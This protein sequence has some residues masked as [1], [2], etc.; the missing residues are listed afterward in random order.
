MLKNLFRF[1]SLLV[2]LSISLSVTGVALAKPGGDLAAASPQDSANPTIS[3]WFKTWADNKT[4]ASVGSYPSVA[5]SP[6]DGLAYISYYDA[7]NH[8][9]MLTSPAA[10]GN[11][12]TSNSWWCRPVDGTG[13]NGSSTDNVGQYSSIAFWKG[14]TSWKLGISY[15]DSTHHA[16]K[17]AVFTQNPSSW[18][19]DF[20]TI[21]NDSAPFGSQDAGLYSSLEFT[22]DGKP[23]IAYYVSMWIS[24]TSS[25]MGVL[26]IA[27]SV[28][29]GGNCGVGTNAVG[30][31]NCE[32]IDADAG[33]GL[34]MYASLD[35]DLYDYP[36]ISYY[37]AVNGNLRYAY[38]LVIVGGGNCGDSGDYQCTTID[39]AGNVGLFTS[40]I[41][42][43]TGSQKTQI[44][45]YDK[46]NGYLMVAIPWTGGTGCNT[47]NWFCNNIKTIGANLSQVGI[48]MARDKDGRPIIA[49][50][51][52]SDDAA[53]A[54]L[55]IARPVEAVGL[56]F[57]NCGQVPPGYLFQVWACDTIDAGGSSYVNVGD[58]ASIA[59]NSNGLASI[60]YSE[61]DSYPYPN[62]FYLKVAYQ[63]IQTHLPLVKK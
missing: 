56:S 29:S 19:W 2:I 14:T 52:A 38:H 53:P 44:A 11:C 46:T 28:S 33:A 48:S 9:L 39:A 45:Y 34:G 49:Y 21:E 41:A 16:L 22:S 50:Q 7:I 40:I 15:Y 26:K 23:V 13:I 20:Y 37:D 18:K 12:G 24:L 62:T 54:A 1:V 61:D 57:G 43:Q 10:S 25:Y 51:D 5:Y 6:I 8:N 31:F 27:E 4:S 55:S 60:A 63:R 58:Y 32:A 59:V 35:L 36:F 42:P 47:S 3:G 30:K 17:L